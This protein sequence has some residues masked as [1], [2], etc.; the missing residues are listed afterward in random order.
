MLDLSLETINQWN[1]DSLQMLYS[2]FYKVLVVY[3]A[4]IIGD[5]E[6]AED[7]VQETFTSLWQKR[8]VF[9]SRLQLKMYLYNTTH[10]YSIS[11]IRRIGREGSKISIPSM[12]KELMLAD[13]D[14]EDVFGPEVYRQ[15]MLMISELPPRQ[16]EAFLLAM[17]GKKNMEIAE[18][19]NISLN[20]VKVLK[21][22]ALQ[23]LKQRAGKKSLILLYFL[24]FL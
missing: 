16:R 14:N 19:M 9:S 12:D 20:T 10:N 5:D 6:N 13:N 4:N 15:L 23:T 18:H 1:D 3:A 21:G 7:I 2:H 11:H 17:E 8:P 22:K 24:P